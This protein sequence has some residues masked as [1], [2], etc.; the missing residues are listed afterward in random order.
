MSFILLASSIAVL[1]GAA[2]GT[3]GVTSVS[4]AT[5]IKGATGTASVS[6]S[7]SSS[8]G[9][10]SSNETQTSQVSVS[11][12][13][14]AVIVHTLE[15]GG[16]V[17]VSFTASDGILVRTAESSAS[18]STSSLS[19]STLIVGASSSGTIETTS[20]SEGASILSASSS[21]EVKVSSSAVS[22]LI[23][24]TEGQGNVSTN[25]S[26]DGIL[27]R[28]AEGQGQVAIASSSSAGVTVFPSANGTIQLLASTEATRTVGLVSLSSLQVISS[29]PIASIIHTLISQDGILSVGSLSI[30]T[31]VVQIQ[32]TDGKIS[33]L[34]S[35]EGSLTP[36]LRRSLV[37]FKQLQRAIRPDQ[38]QGIL[39]AYDTFSGPTITQLTPEI[40]LMVVANYIIAFPSGIRLFPQEVGVIVS[41]F[42][43]TNPTGQPSLKFGTT[44]NTTK[45]LDSSATIGLNNKF[46]RYKFDVLNS[47]DGETEI[48]M[49]VSIAASGS[50]GMVLKG[51][52]YVAGLLVQDQI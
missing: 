44:G 39:V 45:I 30:P 8:A 34:S 2:S 42:S 13:S 6:V 23:F 52:L 11:S 28:S 24:A 12:L 20:F 4:D 25:S 18:L 36:P 14:D 7:A 47:T 38:G 16:S 3:V 9:I 22:G 51:R 27:V 40:D 32:S 41:S 37:Q 46:Q 26:S 19:D 49:G 50:S 10:I 17:T 5:L 29:S 33:I 31:Y 15:G 21:A 43:G 48:L 35:S 1:S